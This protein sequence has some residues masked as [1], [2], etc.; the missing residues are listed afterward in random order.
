MDERKKKPT[1]IP[2]RHTVTGQPSKTETPAERFR[3]YSEQIEST[4]VE[5]A[6]IG[7]DEHLQ[8]GKESR[9]DAA[10]MDS[11]DVI[12]R[13][14]EQVSADKVMNSDLKSQLDEQELVITHLQKQLEHA[15]RDLAT[16]KLTN[17]EKL[18]KCEVD[19]GIVHILEESLDVSDMG[20]GFGKLGGS[21]A[22]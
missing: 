9:S 14:H 12:K 1:T 5:T 21:T 16:T 19:R 18:K 3:L 15:K 7:I 10:E 6:L 22:V 20:I 4:E 2:W 17:E 8:L 13:L 11:V